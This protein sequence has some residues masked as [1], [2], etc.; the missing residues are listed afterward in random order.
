MF[1]K[2]KISTST[3]LVLKANCIIAILINNYINTRKNLLRIQLLIKINIIINFFKKK[4][5]N[6]KKL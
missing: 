5:K 1:L 3:L 2:K 4:I 6:A